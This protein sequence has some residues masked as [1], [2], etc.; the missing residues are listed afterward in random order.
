[1]ALPITN[2]FS[3]CYIT[4]G[5][6]TIPLHK[7]ILATRAPA[8]KSVVCS[9][10]ANIA[11][12][13]KHEHY[14]IVFAVKC[15]YNNDVL[16]EEPITREALLALEDFGNVELMKKA[17]GLYVPNVHDIDSYDRNMIDEKYR[18]DYDDAIV[19]SLRLFAENEKCDIYVV[20]RASTEFLTL[21]FPDKESLSPSTLARIKADCF[22]YMSEKLKDQPEF[23][24]ILS[25]YG[26]FMRMLMQ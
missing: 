23:M 25:S 16:P 10:I 26:Y 2:L 21:A 7:I 5:T 12:P 15:I 8:L 18:K 4:C 1:M 19:R 3:D 22:Q 6:R 20:Y 17:I 11:L 13:R 9:P 24:T 14:D